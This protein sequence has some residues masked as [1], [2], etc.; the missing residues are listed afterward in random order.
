MTEFVNEV[1]DTINE[2]RNLV[3]KLEDLRIDHNTMTE[4]QAR[5]AR[6]VIYQQNGKFGRV[7]MD[8]IKLRDT[9]ILEKFRVLNEEHR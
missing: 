4:S 6:H 7:F 2:L 9:N 8:H 1:R 3:Q 5:A